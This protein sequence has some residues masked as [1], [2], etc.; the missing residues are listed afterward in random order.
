MLKNL[1]EKA[2]D[3]DA[4]DPIKAYR[5]EYYMPKDGG[6]DIYYFCGNSLGLQPKKAQLYIQEALDAWAQMGVEGH[7]K[8]SRPWKPYHHFLTGPSAR[9]AG[10]KEH[11]VV[12]MNTLTTNLHLLMASFY[13]PTKSRYKIIMEG[14]AFPSDQYAVESQVKLHGFAPEDA[15]VEI[16]PEPGLQNLTTAQIQKVIE[17]HGK[18]TAL[19]F[20]GGVNYYTGQW[21]DL[22]AITEAAHK[23]GAYAGFDLAH[24]AGNLP[25]ELH[26]WNVDFAAW[27]SY[28]YLNAGPGGPSGVFIHERHGNNAELPRFAGW[29]GHDEAERFQMKKGFKPMEGAGGWQLSNAQIFSFAAHLASLELFDEVGM[30]AL[31]KKS[32]LLTGFLEECLD[33]LNESGIK[34][35]TI[36]PKNPEHRGCQLSLF[37]D[38]KKGKVLHQQLRKHNIITDWREP[39]VIR[40]APVPMY[41]KFEEVH[42]FAKTLLEIN[43]EI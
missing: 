19:V 10:A 17:A 8:G 16:H 21:F 18:E 15:I 42:Y 14:G 9:I 29:W 36:T 33:A 25:M 26:D 11:E 43:R 23:A 38:R 4:Q 3:L 20:F 6:R 41:N 35:D 12:V 34:I 32:I 27:C 37:V 13:R 28:K 22:K 1:L 5:D 30:A 31:R 2:R 40:L 39:N 24:A 7:V